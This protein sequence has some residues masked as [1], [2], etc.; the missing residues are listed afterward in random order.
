MFE[1]VG[2]ACS[3]FQSQDNNQTI[4]GWNIYVQ[5][6]DKKVTGYKCERL[7][8]NDGKCDYTPALGDRINVIYNRYGKV[9]SIYKV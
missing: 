8:L 2:F 9:D 7:Y 4:T 6:E 5:Y 3:S 1:V